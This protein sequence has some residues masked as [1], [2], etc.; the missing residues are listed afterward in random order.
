MGLCPCGENQVHTNLIGN[1]NS[2]P[3]KEGEHP[4]KNL[5]IQS[6][7]L[8]SRSAMERTDTAEDMRKHL[9]A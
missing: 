2:R 1:F 5:P 4:E 9:N 6:G 3:L 7:G 8:N